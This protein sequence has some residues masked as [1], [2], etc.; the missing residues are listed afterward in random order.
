MSLGCSRDCRVTSSQL[1]QWLRPE[2]NL[3][4]RLE[5]TGL[6][7][8]LDVV[9]Q[10][11]RSTSYIEFM[12]LDILEKD[13]DRILSRFVVVNVASPVRRQIGLPILVPW[14]LEFTAKILSASAFCNR[15]PCNGPA[16]PSYKPTA[17]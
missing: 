8:R 1:L 10:R 12:P 7:Y 13:S 4:G 11:V 2:C 5:E 16:Y 6:R 15:K 3:R 14:D 17:S 9:V